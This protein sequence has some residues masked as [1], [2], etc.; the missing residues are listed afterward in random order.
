MFHALLVLPAVAVFGTVAGTV[1]TVLFGLLGLAFIAELLFGF[2]FQTVKWLLWLPGVLGMVVL[3]V[4]GAVFGAVP[5]TLMLI[6][7]CLYGAVLLVGRC[8]APAAVAALFV[9]LRDADVFA[10]RAKR[11]RA[12]AAHHRYF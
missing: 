7:G 6:F 1:L 9:V 5:L 11:D 3:G 4:L 12:G 10:F 2:V 8:A